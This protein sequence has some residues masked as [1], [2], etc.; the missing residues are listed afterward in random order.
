LGQG[1]FGITYR[2]HDA[3]L[4]RTVAIK[5]YLPASLAVR[6]GGT[7]VLP[8]STKLAED[9][10]WGRDR[11][12][13]EAQTLAQ[14]ENTPAVVRVYDF[15]EGNGTAYM[16]MELL[17]GETLET[18]LKREGRLPLGSVE[19]LLHPLL[20]GLERVHATGI[21][22]RDIKPANI[23]LDGEGRP[24]L[25]D[26]GAARAAIAGRTTAMTAVYTPG[27]AAAE[28]FT[29]AT[30]G[31]YTDIYGL[32]A[33]LY[34]CVTGNMPPTSL[35][36]LM[37]DK[38]VPASRT[39]SGSFPPSLLAGIDAGMAL[40]AADRPASIA[41]W[42]PMFAPSRPTKLTPAA[43][44]ALLDGLATRV[45]RSDPGAGGVRTGG[46]RR[47]LIAAAIGLVLIGSAAG[48]YV[49]WQDAEQR[50][51][52][53]RERV[54]TERRL[55]EARERE[56]AEAR[57]REAQRRAE[58]ERAEL[59]RQQAAEEARR[60]AQEEAEA[61][62]RAEEEEAKRQAQVE[63]EETDRRQSDVR[64]QEEARRLAAEEARR[65]AEA[66]AVRRQQEEETRRLAAEEA[67]R[68]ADADAVRRQQEEEARRLAAEEARRKAEADARRTPDEEAR[69]KAAEEA[70]RRQ[71]E[72]AKRL[73]AEEARRKAAEEARRKAEAD[74]KRLQE[75]AA[76]RAGGVDGTWV[77]SLDCYPGGPKGAVNIRIAGGQG[78]VTV[79]G[80][81]V[82]LRLSES[83]AVTDL[84]WI[85]QEGR[86][87]EASL[88]GRPN[89]DALA[90]EGTA[91][92][93]GGRQ[94]TNRPHCRLNL[95]RQ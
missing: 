42:R 90:I 84:A 44:A 85:G 57:V 31:P 3:Q 18:R 33:T 56:E 43:Q 71:E 1:S 2:A 70:K 66:D 61:K 17:R 22:H 13:A 29:S 51:A 32:A 21:L 91:R 76:R 62:R 69:R 12:L 15:L 89:G 16:V 7:Q 55:R 52:L 53:E 35:E 41:A 6:Q 88:R 58:E 46:V 68:K 83:S 48:G 78:A 86:E 38:L 28:Q 25:L 87:W 94:E 19:R 40:K 49:Y 34:Q 9:F 5:E 45:S 54:E 10:R 95:K 14:F 79:Q 82:A 63:R 93:L 92:T 73:A 80:V 27:Y 67:R 37:D 36:R 8:R 59:A 23:I 72:E 20:D 26:F 24:T 74:A 47:S 65:K 39:A 11:F 30:Q 50:A 4:N 81:K 77:G 60:R 64:R 75:E